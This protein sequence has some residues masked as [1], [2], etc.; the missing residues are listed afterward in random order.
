DDDHNHETEVI[1]TVELTFTPDGG[2]APVIANF[3]DPD[4]DGGMSGMADAITLVAGTTY[5]LEIRFL[6][7]LEDPAEDITEEIEEEAEEHM[8]LVFGEGVEG[9][10][11]MPAAPI[12]SH[13]Y[14][15]H[16]SDYTS[17]DVGEDLP[18]GLRNTIVASTTGSSEL[19]V[20]LRHLPALNGTPQKSA[21]IP[22]TYAMGGSVPGD[23]DADI[24]FELN[25]VP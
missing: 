16:E 19:R 13:A 17:N 20:M 8:I 7:A 15:D 23:V 1:S 24:G 3:V 21:N 9:P 12:I 18:V 11:S 2:G 5:T 10:A 4:G 14:A 22:T 6:N 25:V